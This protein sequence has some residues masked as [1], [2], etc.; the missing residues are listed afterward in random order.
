MTIKCGMLQFVHKPVGFLDWAKFFGLD[1]CRC[2]PPNSEKPIISSLTL[3]FAN[4]SDGLCYSA[5][6]EWSGPVATF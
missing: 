5:T 6:V 4:N 2:S 3:D 1:F